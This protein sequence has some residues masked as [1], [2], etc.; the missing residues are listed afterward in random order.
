MEEVKSEIVLCVALA[1]SSLCLCQSLVVRF[2]PLLN[3]SKLFAKASTFNFQLLCL[4]GVLGLV[5]FCIGEFSCK[6][7]STDVISTCTNKR[8]PGLARR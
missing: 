4:A 7:L 6:H 3:V 5:D 8:C 1:L 2:Y